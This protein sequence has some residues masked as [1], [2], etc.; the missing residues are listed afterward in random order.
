MTTERRLALVAAPLAPGDRQRQHFNDAFAAPSSLNDA[1]PTVRW[2]P[3]DQVEPKTRH[4]VDVLD[5]CVERFGLEAVLR[6][7]RLLAILNGRTL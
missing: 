7:V 6:Q 3:A 4:L 2:T 5:I 1:P